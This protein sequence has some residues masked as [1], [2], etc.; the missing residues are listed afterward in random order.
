MNSGVLTE[1]DSTGVG[2]YARRLVV[3]R[4]PSE[5]VKKTGGLGVEP[6]IARRSQ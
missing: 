3:C 1:E 5:H 6:R 4:A 2:A